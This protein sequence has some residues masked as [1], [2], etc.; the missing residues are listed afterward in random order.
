MTH[1]N[2]SVHENAWSAFGLTFPDVL[3]ASPPRAKRV[4][5]LQ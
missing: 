3:G 2:A 1:Y 5:S 4:I